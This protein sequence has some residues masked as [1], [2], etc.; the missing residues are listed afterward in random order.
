MKPKQLKILLAIVA[1]MAIGGIA[2][3]QVVRVAPGTPGG[4]FMIV[5]AVQIAFAGATSGTA[6]TGVPTGATYYVADPGWITASADPGKVT[7]AISAGT[8]TVT[9]ANATTG[10]ACVLYAYKR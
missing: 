10:T 3:A 9:T 2:L 7:A 8:L 5:E 1:V 6:S 4:S